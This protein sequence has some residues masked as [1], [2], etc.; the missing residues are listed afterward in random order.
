MFLLGLLVGL[1]MALIAV[2]VIFVIINR[3]YLIVDFSMDSE[4]PFLLEIT[5]TVDEV[6][7]SK[8]VLLRTIRK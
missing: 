2:I 3:G 5:T 7:K 8:W 6:Y 1:I 4:Q